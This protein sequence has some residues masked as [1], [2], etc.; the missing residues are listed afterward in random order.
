MSGKLGM[1]PIRWAHLNQS[2]I[3]CY[4]IMCNREDVKWFS[5]IGH[6]SKI[7]PTCVSQSQ[8]NSQTATRILS[9]SSHLVHAPYG[10]VISLVVWSNVCVKI[11][12]NQPDVISRKYYV[13]HDM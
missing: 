2:Y 3:N 12:H 13:D 8:L 9:S 6:L 5:A 7:S 1:Y 10:D 4:Q 11:P